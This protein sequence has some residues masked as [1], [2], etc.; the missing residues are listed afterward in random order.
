MTTFTQPY[1]DIEL[2]DIERDLDI[3]NRVFVY[4]TLQGGQCN[5]RLLLS[6]DKLS[7]TTTQD[8][9][10][11]GDVGFPY[12][13]HY[14]VVP[15]EYKKLLHPVKGELYKMDS[16]YTFL[17]LDGL[18]GYPSHYNRRVVKTATGMTAWMYMNDDW[19]SA[20]MCNACKLEEGVW[21]WSKY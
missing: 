9:F 1:N 18:E 8:K 4:G 12:A 5:N 3:C 14:S 21:V 13:F 16:M 6:A 2:A 11:L 7:S 10:A 15:D 19:A 17:Q 20:S